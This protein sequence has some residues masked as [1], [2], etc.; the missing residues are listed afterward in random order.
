MGRPPQ[1]AH[2]HTLTRR[3]PRSSHSHTGRPPPGAHSHTH[4]L[5]GRPPKEPTLTRRPPRSSHSRD[6]PQ[7]LIVTLAHSR[8][9]PQ[10][11]TLTQSWDAPLKELTLTHSGGAPPGAHTHT[12]DAPPPELIVTLT[13]SWDASPRSPHSRGAPQELTLTHGA[14]PGAHTHTIMGRPPG[15][16]THTLT[17]PRTSEAPRRGP[18]PAAARRDAADQGIAGPTPRTTGAGGGERPPPRL[19]VR[20]RD[21][22]TRRRRP[23]APSAP[24]GATDRTPRPPEPALRGAPGHTDAADQLPVRARGS[25]PPAPR[26]TRVPLAA[27]RRRGLPVRGVQAG[28]PLRAG[29]HPDPVH[30]YCRLL[31]DSI[32]SSLKAPT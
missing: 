9:T 1:G 26:R 23:G 21:P 29:S 31:P 17:H 5:M 2:T 22:E 28:P 3:P 11:L 15:A 6:A 24:A 14:P 12:R 27:G 7:E 16:H 30:P 8:G 18:R 4:T 20:L 13:H 32:P 19:T 10:E 25:A